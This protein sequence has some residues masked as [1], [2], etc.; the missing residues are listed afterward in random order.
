MRR[1][2]YSRL[3]YRVETNPER[4]RRLNSA[5]LQPT[6]HTLHSTLH[7]PSDLIMKNNYPTEFTDWNQVSNI[8]QTEYNQ[9][10][11]LPIDVLNTKTGDGTRT[12]VSWRVPPT[13]PNRTHLDL[14]AKGIRGEC[15]EKRVYDPIL[16]NYKRLNLQN[17]GFHDF[18]WERKTELHANDNWRIVHA[19]ACQLDLTDYQKI[20]VQIFMSHIKVNK[21]GHSTEEIAF[22]ACMVVCW[23]DGRK[24]TPRHRPIDIEFS[25]LI[26]E[27]RYHKP[28][29]LL[30]KVM[31]R[32]DELL[33]P[34]ESRR[35]HPPQPTNPHSLPSGRSVSLYAAE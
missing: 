32:L 30:E 11:I 18:K 15:R 3:L 29:K 34:P 24:S 2:K 9:T 13:Q 10:P 8:V 1:F 27:Q 7:G 31:D 20:R 5:R 4:L 26:K 17:T 25:K 21:T 22:A 19:I 14:K 6:E 16:P 28:L 33:L 35:K 23:E 12:R